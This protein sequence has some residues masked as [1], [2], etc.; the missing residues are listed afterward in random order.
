M[1]GF[2][3]AGQNALFKTEPSL[4]FASMKAD[5]EIQ[6]FQDIRLNLA[7]N[8]KDYNSIEKAGMMGLQT[9]VGFSRWKENLKDTDYEEGENGEKIYC[10]KIS[11]HTHGINLKTLKMIEDLG[12]IKIDSIEDRLN[13]KGEYQEEKKLLI[14]EK[15]GFKNYEDLKRIAIATLKGDRKTLESMKKT[16]KKVTFR[17]T[18]KKIDFEELYRKSADINSIADKKEQI[19][20]RRLSVIFDNKQGILS[21]KNIDIRKD[22]FGRDVIKYNTKESFGQRLNK[23]RQ[24]DYDTEK[25][26]SNNEVWNNQNLEICN[27][28]VNNESL[29]FRNSLT[30]NVNRNGIEQRAEVALKQKQAINSKRELTNIEMEEK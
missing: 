16:F 17:L 7:S 30:Q 22:S 6:I 11:T 23:N 4:M 29:E 19:A 15:L 21:T 20:L 12:Y 24:M 8:M 1:G 5:G 18:D 25:D 28:L 10:E 27:N 13:R 26:N 3:K 2:V 9:L 14:L